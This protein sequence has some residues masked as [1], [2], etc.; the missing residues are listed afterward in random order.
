MFH[1]CANCHILRW[2]WNTWSQLGPSDT[3]VSSVLWLKV[4]VRC[5]KAIRSIYKSYRQSNS[6]QKGGCEEWSEDWKKDSV[7]E[8]EDLQ[9]GSCWSQNM[10]CFEH[11]ME[12]YGLP[13]QWILFVFVWFRGFLV[14]LS[15]F[16]SFF[17]F[18][19]LLRI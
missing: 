5:R 9:C 13:N 3:E 18:H 12:T 16:F 7:G 1:Q 15:N 2:I 6:E 17:L 19:F 8:W 4:Q 11:T 14:Y 10:E